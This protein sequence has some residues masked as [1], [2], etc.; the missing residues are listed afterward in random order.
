MLLISKMSSFQEHTLVER[1]AACN[2]P[3]SSLWRRKNG[4]DVRE[5]SCCGFR[6]TYQLPSEGFLQ[7]YCAES[8]LQDDGYFKPKG[9]LLRWL[10]YKLFAHYLRHAVK[11]H[12]KSPSGDTR[13]VELGCGQGDLLKAFLGDQTVHV[14]GMDYAKG[15][16]NHLKS[17]GFDAHVGGLEEVPVPHEHLDAEVMLHVLEHVREPYAVLQ[18]AFNLLKAGGILYAVCPCSS[19]IKARIAGDQW[20]YL[21][22]PGHLSYFTPPSFRKMAE[23][24]G[25]KVLRCS[26][27][28]HR[29]HVTVVA[30]KSNAR[31]E[32]H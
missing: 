18:K 14:T 10:K 23:R 6:Y 24:A 29:A 8:Y 21:W 1:C 2:S 11:A 32:A 19:H 16:I 20:K 27:F 4:Y 28:Y 9:G 7:N 30:V 31:A 15:P 3:E 13:I 25:F 26:N 22:P 12:S 5:C 17:L